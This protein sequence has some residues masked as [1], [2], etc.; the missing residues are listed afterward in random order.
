MGKKAPS[1]TVVAKAGTAASKASA[2]AGKA[3]A[4][5]ESSFQTG[6]W[7]KSLISDKDI[8]ELQGQGLL[9]GMEYQLPGNE[10]IPN[11]P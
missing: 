3:P 9:D 8:N 7:A 2:A 1:K 4:E 5:E 10:E 6:D 11:P